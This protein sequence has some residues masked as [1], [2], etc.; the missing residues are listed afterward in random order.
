MTNRQK[1]SPQFMQEIKEFDGT[2]RISLPSNY[3]S[4]LKE[5]FVP[6]FHLCAYGPIPMGQAERVHL[7]IDNLPMPSYEA[8]EE[9]MW[10]Y[11]RYMSEQW[12]GYE[13]DAD[14]WEIDHCILFGGN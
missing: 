8:A 13:F 7:V 2:P 9:C 10:D 6:C 3:M 11:I 14:D 12:A 5:E 1:V 4:W